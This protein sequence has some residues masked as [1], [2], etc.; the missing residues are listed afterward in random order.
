M[1]LLKVEGLCKK[2]TGFELK[3]VSFSLEKGYIMGFIGRNG[4]GKTTTLKSMV[5]LVHPNGGKVEICGMDFS[6]NELECKKMLHLCSA[7]QIIT[8]RKSLKR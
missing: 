5:N 1:E 6:D 8:R 4:A 7:G 3:N 2:Y